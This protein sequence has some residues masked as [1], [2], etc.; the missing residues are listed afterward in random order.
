MFDNKITNRF[1]MI[2]GAR[3]EQFNQRVSS[4]AIGKK[5]D[6][7][8]TVTDVL[9]SLNIIY[10]LTENQNLRFSYSRT[11]SRP[12]FREFAPLA[13]YEVNYNSIIIGN[14]TLVRALIDNIDFKWEFFPS[15]AQTISINPFYKR[16]TN[17]VEMIVV[18]NPSFRNFS[19]QNASSAENIGVEIETRLLLIGLDKLAG[20]NI[21]KDM[22]LYGNLALINSQVNLTNSGAG[23]SKRPLQ[24]QSPYVFNMGLNYNNPKLF[25]VAVNANRVGRRIAFVGTSENQ[26]IWENPRTVLDIS[27]SKTLFKRLQAKFVVGDVFA[28]RLVF[29]H[30]LNRNGSFDEGTDADAFN[31]RY[32]RSFTIGLSYTL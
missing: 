26:T 21:F 6:I 30:D 25:D 8:K 28:Q 13:F 9:P 12:E 11:L 19:Y 14:D 24:G 10:E 29:Y 31:Y 4:E 3:I 18:P 2:W 1:R 7:N 16:F 23:L 32:G 27:L 15:A 17:P 5:V 22:T 20:T